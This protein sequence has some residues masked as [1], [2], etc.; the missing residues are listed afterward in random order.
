[1]VATAVVAEDLLKR[2]SSVNVRLR[3]IGR[4]IQR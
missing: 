4:L 2:V 3:L 1:M